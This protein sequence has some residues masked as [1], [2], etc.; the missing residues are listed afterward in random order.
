MSRFWN[1]IYKH[2][3]S[4]DLLI[5]GGVAVLFLLL[6]GASHLLGLPYLEWILLAALIAALFMLKTIIS[7]VILIVLIAVGSLLGNLILV[8]EGA[9]VPFSLFQIF[10]LYSLFIFFLR[11]LFFGFGPIIKTGFE[12]EIL[13]FFSLIF[14]SFLWTPDA[15]RAFFHAVRVFMLSGLLL[16]IV[17]WA[18]TP[19]H[20]IWII[21]SLALVGGIIG[22]VAVIDT[23]NNPIA[24]IQDLVTDGT[25]S[26]SRARI[27]QVDPNVF[28]SLFFLPLAFTASVSFSKLNPLFRL[29][30]AFFFVLLITAVMVTFSRSS[31]VSIL[32]M[33][34]ILTVLFRQYKLFLLSF[35]IIAVLA[36]SLPDF[37]LLLQNILKRFL[38]IFTGDVDTSNYLRIILFKTS[39]QIFFDSWLLG[40]GWRG[41]PD[42]F[43]SYHSIQE[44]LGVYEPHNVIYLVYTELGLIGLF[45]FTFIVYKIFRIAF[46]NIRLSIREEEK[47][48]SIALFSAF[49]GYAIFY[50]FLGSGFLDN[51]LWITTGLILSLNF[52]LRRPS[53]TSENPADDLPDKPGEKDSGTLFDASQ[54]VSDKNLSIEG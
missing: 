54:N 4:S 12:T 8:L 45:L 32:G 3:S 47:V 31:W 36:I 38:G 46:S 16:L 23:I 48:L 13:L 7:P 30:S 34:V 1:Y 39:F 15:E 33:L 22:M 5:V 10:Y 53:A 18:K 17:N 52:Y 26:T 35:V 24:I 14:L 20:I 25:R 9:T 19:I 51:Q 11:W 44:T 40:V 21:S 50:Q 37:T 42:A 29:L 43:L 6:Q 28:A 2:T 27:G 41:F 49:L